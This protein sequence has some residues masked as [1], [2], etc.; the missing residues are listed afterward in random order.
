MFILLPI[1]E[2]VLS[3]GV[4]TAAIN[5]NSDIPASSPELVNLALALLVSNFNNRLIN[6]WLIF[7]IAPGHAVS[8]CRQ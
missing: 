5:N 4:T 7:D 2:T 3:I 8:Y 1:K 6:A